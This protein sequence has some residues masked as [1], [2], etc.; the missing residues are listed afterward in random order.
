MLGWLF[1]RAHGKMRTPYFQIC[2][3]WLD[4][5]SS[6]KALHSL[7][8]LQDFCPVLFFIPTLC[9]PNFTWKLFSSVDVLIWFKFPI[10]FIAYCHFGIF[11]FFSG[12]QYFQDIY[13]SVKVTWNWFQSCIGKRSRKRW[14][15]WPCKALFFQETSLKIIGI[16]R[17]MRTENNVIQ[18]Y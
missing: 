3:S 10:P 7:L 1:H 11:G 4:S 14:T 12:T 15:L 2:F 5:P 16:W 18:A 8:Q 13:P 17:W 6:K 9:S